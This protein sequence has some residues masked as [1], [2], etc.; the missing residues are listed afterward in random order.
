M[1]WLAAYA[2][3]RETVARRGTPDA[4]FET[5]YFRMGAALVAYLVWASAVP[6]LFEAPALQIVAAF[7]AL[8][9]SW[10]LSQ[11]QRVLGA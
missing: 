4:A 3:F 11:V 10:V 6:S 8:V 9:I 2:T 7:A 5:P 1:L